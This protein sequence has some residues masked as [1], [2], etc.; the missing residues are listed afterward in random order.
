M[1]TAPL[2]CWIHVVGMD[3]R[4]YQEGEITFEPLSERTGISELDLL[5]MVEVE[6]LLP[7]LTQ[8]YGKN[9]LN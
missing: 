8:G 4:L 9:T 6:T 5:H 7:P 2:R 3:I 1:K